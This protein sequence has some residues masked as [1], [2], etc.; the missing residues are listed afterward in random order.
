MDYR[1]WDWL[2]KRARFHQNQSPGF[3]LY[4]NLVRINNS[5]TTAIKRP[6]RGPNQ[7]GISWLMF[8]IVSFCY[9]CFYTGKWKCAWK[10]AFRDMNVK[11]RASQPTW[12]MQRVAQQSGHSPTVEHFRST[13]YTKP[14]TGKLPELPKTTLKFPTSPFSP[15]ANKPTFVIF[16]Y[17]PMNMAIS[18]TGRGKL[19]P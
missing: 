2:T 11:V 6:P 4:H 19:P 12:A 10:T 18:T 1:L 8:L 7:H 13:L 5:E 16:Q 17:I 14:K 9:S 3:F 15:S